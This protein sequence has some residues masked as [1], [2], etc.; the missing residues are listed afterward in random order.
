MMK[1]KSKYQQE[2]DV[3]PQW[4]KYMAAQLKKEEKGD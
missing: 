2:Y 4:A 3:L 1:E